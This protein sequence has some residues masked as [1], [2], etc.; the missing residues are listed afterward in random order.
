MPNSSGL[1]SANI[2]G[3]SLYITAANVT[4]SRTALPTTALGDK[5]ETNVYGVGRISGSV[6]VMYDKTAHANMVDQVEQASSSVTGTFTWDTGDTWTGQLL[7]TEAAATVSVDDLVK[8][9]ISFVG[10]GS[11]TA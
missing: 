1:S 3:A 11:W 4:I 9:T 10:T 5:W 8:A 7:V 6:E 2:G